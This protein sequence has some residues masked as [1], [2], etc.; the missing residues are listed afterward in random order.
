MRTY[1]YKMFSVVINSEHNLFKKE[2]EKPM[3]YITEDELQKP[4][5]RVYWASILA[6][7][8]CASINIKT[9]DK[10]YLAQMTEHAFDVLTLTLISYQNT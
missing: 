10:D 7:E 2:E 9:E 8:S 5:K 6:L 3:L 4:Y 1:T